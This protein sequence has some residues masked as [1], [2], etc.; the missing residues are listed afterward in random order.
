M[1]F[2]IWIIFQSIV[3]TLLHFLIS[4]TFTLRK[5]NVSKKSWQLS[6]HMIAI[7]TAQCRELSWPISSAILEKDSQ[8]EKVTIPLFLLYPV[9][10]HHW[11]HI[12]SSHWN[13]FMCHFFFKFQWIDCSKKPKPTHEVLWDMKIFSEL[14]SHHCQII[15]VSRNIFMCCCNL[16]LTYANVHLMY[17]MYVNHVIYS[18]HFYAHL[19]LFHH[20]SKFI[21]SN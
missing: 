15:D 9:S 20:E 13:F 12:C 21:H 8:M 5:R 19:L 1:S 18:F 3:L 11:T 14:C 16:N 6:V 2:H 7:T 10:L 17:Q 4:C